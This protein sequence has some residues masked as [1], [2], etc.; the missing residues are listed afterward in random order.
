MHA[1]RATRWAM[2]AGLLALAAT[3]GPRPGH[4]QVDIERIRQ[5]SGQEGFSLRATLSLSTRSGNVD[6]TN[7]EVGGRA[8]LVRSRNTVFVAFAGD[9][10]WQG[11]KQFSDQGLTHLRY[12]RG[13]RGRLASEVFVQ[14]DYDKARLLD[15]RG[16]AGA[17]L[18]LELDSREG[19]GVSLGSS[20]MF[21]HEELDL[22][23]TARHPA[24]TDANRW[25]SYAGL[26]WSINDHSGVSATAYVQPRFEDLGDYRVI[27]EGGLETRV[28]GAVALS[29]TGRLRH[30]SRPPDGIESTDTKLGTGLVVSF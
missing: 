12:I 2:T 17:G 29:V 26:R 22:P 24:R 8:Q 25:S 13:L 5:Q 4:A 1:S 27:A 16:L 9:Y 15:R 3:V 18:R 20:Y 6:A 7:L 30:D 21:E 23:A 10:G 19:T 14:G 11:G 28:G